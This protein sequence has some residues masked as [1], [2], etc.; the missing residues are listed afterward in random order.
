M[1]DSIAFGTFNSLSC[2]PFSCHAVF[3]PVIFDSSSQPKAPQDSSD[4]T[5]TSHH[6]PTSRTL[7]VSPIQHCIYSPLFLAIGFWFSND[8]AAS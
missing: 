8:V 5:I 7:C 1:L 6:R 3:P 4:L 2:M